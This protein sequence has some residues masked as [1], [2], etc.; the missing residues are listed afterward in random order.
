[1]KTQMKD[2]IDISIEKVYKSDEVI[3]KELK[4]YQVI[5]HLLDVFVRAAVNNQQNCKSAFDDLA[6]ACIPK[7]YLHKEAIT[8]LYE[9]NM[10]L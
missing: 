9:E 6:I 4:G 1:M 3:E 7:S 8:S 5:H 2:I 10:K